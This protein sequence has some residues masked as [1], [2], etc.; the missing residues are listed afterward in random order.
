MLWLKTFW[1]RDEIMSMNPILERALPSTYQHINRLLEHHH[2]L[3]QYYPNLKIIIKS[4]M[5]D[6][7]FD[8]GFDKLT[9]FHFS[10]T[11]K[12]SESSLLHTSFSNFCKSI[13]SMITATLCKDFESQKILAHRSTIS[14]VQS[15]LSEYT[16]Y[17]EM[18]QKTRERGFCHVIVFS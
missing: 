7:A 13:N 14:V 10:S 17:H 8:R 3:W 4:I 1:A 18:P 11:V 15:N 16:E 9:S 2:R 6:S 5:N 12:W